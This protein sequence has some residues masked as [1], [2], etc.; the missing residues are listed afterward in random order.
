[1]HFSTSLIVS[2][3][4][5]GTYAKRCTNLIVPF[6]LTARNAVFDIEPIAI[7]SDATRF[8]Q[9]FTS[10]AGNYSDT[11]LRGYTTVNGQYHL[12]AT[13]CRPDSLN[14]SASTLQFLTHGIGF[15]KLYWDL[16][17]NNFN[18]SYVDVAVDQYGY[19]SFAIDRFGIGNSSI[20]DPLDVVQLPAELAA[21]YEVTEMVR[22]GKVEG[23]PAPRKIVHVGHSFG[24]AL[25]FALA[26]TYPAA[27]DG[28]VLTGFSPSDATLYNVFASFNAKLARLN[29]P[30]RFGDVDVEKVAATLNQTIRT[31]QQNLENAGVSAMELQSIIQYTSVIDLVTGLNPSGYPRAQ[32]LSSGYLVWSDPGSIQ[33]SFYYPNYFDPNIIIYAESI[34]YPFSVGEALTQVGSTPSAAPNFTGSVLVITGS[35]YT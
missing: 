11:A 1:M 5:V 25:S 6:S 7:N 33:Y 8:F 34:K 29:Q 26:G 27:S 9:R 13:Y 17:Y 3:L 35:K 14:S 2:T 23:V 4:A 10:N 31:F 21:I 22:A 28:L 32:N 30:L 16:P 15:D 20:A 18:Y 24:S 19:S 12:S